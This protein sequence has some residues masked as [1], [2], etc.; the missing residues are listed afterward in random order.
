MNFLTENTVLKNLDQNKYDTSICYKIS[1]SL[2]DYIIINT[3][4]IIYYMTYDVFEHNCMKHVW[5]MQF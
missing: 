2:R 1:E 5:D 3:I 4:E